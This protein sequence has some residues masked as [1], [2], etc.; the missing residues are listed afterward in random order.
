MPVPAGA[1]ATGGGTAAG[2][3]GELAPVATGAAAAGV[4][5][6]T[7]GAGVPA[8]RPTLPGCAV[9]KAT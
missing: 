6:A 3:M 9:V 8:T 4:G 5:E 1:A 7:A 2:A